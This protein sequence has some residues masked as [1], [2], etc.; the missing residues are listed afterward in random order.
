VFVDGVNQYSGSTYS[1]VE[2]SA[3]TVTFDSGL[4]VGALVKFTTVQSL[5]S[6]QETDAALVTYNEGGTGAVTTTVR[7]KLQEII[8]VK[9]FGAV[10]DGITDDTVAIQ[11]AIDSAHSA[12]VGVIY[13]P[14]GTY[15]I[16][17]TLI[18]YPGIVL[19]GNNPVGEYYS[20]FSMA[21]GATFFKNN[22]VGV[23]AA[24]PFVR[25]CSASSV[26]G[27][28]F[29]STNTG[30]ALN[31]GAV[32]FGQYGATTTDVVNASV[33]NCSFTLQKTGNVAAATTTR[34]IFFPAKDVG[35]ANYFNRVS[36]V[37]INNCDIAIG[38][39]SQCNA[40]NFANIITRECYIH[41][42]LNGAASECIENTF[43]GLSLFSIAVLSPVAIGF[44]LS[45]NVKNNAF[46]SYCTEMNGQ[47]FS[48][49][50]SCENN[51][52]LGS[53]NESTPSYANGQIDYKYQVPNN[54]S[55]AVT[56]PFVSGVLGTRN[57]IGSGSSFAYQF[58]ISGTLPQQNNN[59][60]TIIAGNVNNKVLFRLPD[61]FTK[62]SKSSFFGKLK[63]F[64]YGPFGNG[65]GM[66]DV[67]F[68]Y[69][70]RDETTN[71]GQFS[72]FRVS[73]M[74]NEITG[75]YFLT[76]V[77]AAQQMG[78]ALVGGNYGAYSFGYI[79][80]VLEINVFSYSA[81]TD[82]FSAYQDMNSTTAAAV[83]ANDVTDAITLL[84]VG[85]TTV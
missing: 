78:V 7:A 1:Y 5:T 71:Q 11:A 20:G 75:L 42:E 82:F 65:C 61:L 27:I 14:N 43:T 76:G 25:L 15:L 74:G 18:L 13:V 73:T 8:S 22:A 12:G 28:F 35:H 58:E 37:T 64:A 59:A 23:A 52:F 80:C 56:Y 69:S 29:R 38:M 9:D 84:T 85:N 17:G 47:E 60:G 66:V 79:K 50:S 53:S 6:G 51:R 44:K 63:V 41:Y 19:Y 3:S 46:I 40:N 62:T 32:S 31:L 34:A 36:N 57:S 49:D 67:D 48:I 77:A 45:N 39:Q 54:V 10:G 70:L 21:Y 83:T 33:I 55:N 24:S 26:C 81:Y 4:H 2:T 72:V 30:Q 68:G 16:Y